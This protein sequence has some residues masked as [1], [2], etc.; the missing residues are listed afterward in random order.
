MNTQKVSCN[1]CMTVYKTD[2]AG[3]DYEKH[4][5]TLIQDKDGSYFKGCRVC[6]TDEYLIDI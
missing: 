3:Y 2:E 5:L 1:N 6:K 4:T